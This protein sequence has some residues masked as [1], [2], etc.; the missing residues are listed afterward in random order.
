MRTQNVAL[1][2]LVALVLAT[3]VI[4]ASAGVDIVPTFLFSIRDGK[5]QTDYLVRFVGSQSGELAPQGSI[6]RPLPGEDVMVQIVQVHAGVHLND[7][8][9]YTSRV[10]FPKRKG[11]DWVRLDRDEVF[12]FT[13]D[14]GY[15]GQ[16][17]A[18]RRATPL[19]FRVNVEDGES[20]ELRIFGIKEPIT[21]GLMSLFGWDHSDLVEYAMIL[22]APS[23]PQLTPAPA[24][25]ATVDGSQFADAEATAENFR[26]FAGTVEGIQE[27][28]SAAFDCINFDLV[29]LGDTVAENSQA[30]ADLQAEVDAL[31]AWQS[32]VAG[33]PVLVPPTAVIL[34][35]S[36]TWTATLRQKYAGRSGLIYVAVGAD[37]MP[38]NGHMTL[39][40]YQWVGTR[41]VRNVNSPIETDDGELTLLWTPADRAR[42]SARGWQGFGA[43]LN[44]SEPTVKC[45]LSDNTLKIIAVP[46]T[47][48]GELY[49]AQ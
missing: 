13:A 5:V 44:G 24:T 18:E 14:L 25:V 26:R 42:W 49:E 8:A 19:R 21:N 30:I 34:A 2:A 20:H 6:L 23:T 4:P 1:V 17:P 3:S 35:S 22:V 33:M 43:S 39:T 7:F 36:T 48:G 15:F 38:T 9:F 37:G 27:Q 45:M 46:V 12:G 31:K 28:L 41:W 32:Q 29:E 11:P 10:A 47:A 40:L 16:N